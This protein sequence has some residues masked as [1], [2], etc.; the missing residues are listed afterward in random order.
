MIKLSPSILAS[1]FAHL[2]EQVNRA[3][4]GGADYIHID[5]MDGMF[6]PNISLGI[7]VIRSLKK[8]CPYAFFDVHLMI[9]QPERYISRFRDAGADMITVHAEATSM[10][11]STLLTIRDMGC[12][13][14]VV[15]N[16]ETPLSRL[17]GVLDCIDMVLLMTVTPGFGGQTYMESCTQ[18]ISDLR[19][20]IDERNLNVDIEVD[21]GIK[22]DNVRTVIEAGANVIVVGSGVFEGDITGNVV[23]FKKIFA[24][25][26]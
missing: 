1:N 3:L 6:V 22:L 12:K 26:Q 18:K 13:A 8:A 17:E 21:G 4:E 23:E 10:L 7:P 5:V 16:P 11:R 19:A 14:G 2:E 25:Y 9:V 15:L 24:E 20:M